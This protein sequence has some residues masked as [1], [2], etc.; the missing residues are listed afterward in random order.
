MLVKSSVSLKTISRLKVGGTAKNIFYPET[1][2]EFIE[3]LK[4]YPKPVIVGGGSNVFFADKVFPAVIITT[5]LNKLSKAGRSGFWAECGVLLPKLFSF[6][7]GVPAT[8]GGGLWMNFGAFRQEIQEFVEEVEIYDQK[9]RKVRILDRAEIVFGYRH[10]SFEKDK[11]IILRARFKRKSLVNSNKLLKLRQA[12]LPYDK[13]NIGSIFRNPKEGPAGYYIDSAG[14]KGFTI[15]G[16]MVS[17][18]HANIIVNN[19]NAKARDVVAL[20]KKIKNTVKAKFNIELVPE[21]KYVK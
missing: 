1:I 7:A 14:L 2:A 16:A 13:P 18:K 11:Q 17:L 3:L 4:K 21:V 5:K 20:I 15:G 8:V 10:A 6:A 9:K 19:G 12:A